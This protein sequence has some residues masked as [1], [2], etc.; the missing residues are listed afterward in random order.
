M[1][2]FEGQLN[3]YFGLENPSS[4]VVA[5]ATAGGNLEKKLVVYGAPDP[6]L[7]LAKRGADGVYRLVN[8]DR[9]TLNL[10]RFIF[11]SIQLSDDGEYKIWG[12]N[13]YGNSEYTFRINVT[14]KGGTKT[15][16]HIA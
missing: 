13:S 14:G 2:F 5:T 7:S 8:D 16:A 15:V 10:T 6:I 12:N 1:H 4:P 9:V 11:S 3:V